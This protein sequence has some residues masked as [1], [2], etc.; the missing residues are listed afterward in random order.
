[1]KKYNTARYNNR[2][3]LL[4]FSTRP[5]K[6]YLDNKTTVPSII[7]SLSGLNNE[8]YNATKKM[9]T[10]KKH[11]QTT[12]YFHFIDRGPFLFIQLPP[13]FLSQQQQQKKHMIFFKII[14]YILR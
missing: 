11:Y 12:F 1:M 9:Y 3:L 8:N 6:I 7:V 10:K 2:L 14:I 4:D 13:P 5:N